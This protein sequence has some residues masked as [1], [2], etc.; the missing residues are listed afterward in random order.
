MVITKG[1]WLVLLT[2]GVAYSADA[3]VVAPKKRYRVTWEER[4]G[5]IDSDSVCA[6]HKNGSIAY[7]ECRSY[8][9]DYFHAQCHKHREGVESSVGAK[10]EKERTLRDKFCNIADRFYP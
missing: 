6:D 10:R 9:I 1:V 4:D 2:L 5:R 7:R 3:G 8:A